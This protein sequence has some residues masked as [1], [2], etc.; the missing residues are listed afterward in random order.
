MQ[1]I[2]LNAIISDFFTFNSECEALVLILFT[3]AGI[4][5]FIFLSQVRDQQREVS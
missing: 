3:P 5:S 1:S 4:Q 2:L